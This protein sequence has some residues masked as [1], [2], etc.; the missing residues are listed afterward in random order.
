MWGQPGGLCT[1]QGCH[2]PALPTPAL[3]PINQALYP[4][5]YTPYTPSILPPHLAW[6]CTPS[7]RSVSHMPSP[8]CCSPYTPIPIH[9]TWHTQPYS[10]QP[11]HAV[12]C[13]SPGPLCLFTLYPWPCTLH[14]APPA[15]GTQ[16][17]LAPT[18]TLTPH[19]H[20]VP[21]CSTVQR[22]TTALGAP[23]PKGCVGPLG[24]PLPSMLVP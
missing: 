17:T 10:L 3:G 24:T 19:A 1:C 7:I 11:L 13:T 14:A 2:A 18:D 23:S 12:P 9:H 22:E 5:P 15:L 4:C 20:I 16:T 21:G 6:H 8:T